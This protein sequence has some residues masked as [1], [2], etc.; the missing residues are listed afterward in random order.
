VELGYPIFRSNPEKGKG[1]FTH[2]YLVIQKGPK[3]DQI[4]KFFKKKKRTL[5]Q[6]DGTFLKLNDIVNEYYS[7]IGK[8]GYEDVTVGKETNIN[9]DEINLTKEEILKKILE[10]N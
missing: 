3:A 2:F 9:M 8:P 5:Q 6:P 10:I 4:Q 7:G 1:E